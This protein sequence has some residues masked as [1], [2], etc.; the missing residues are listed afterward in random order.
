MTLL[1]YFKT[2]SPAGSPDWAQLC[3]SCLLAGGGSARTAVRHPDGSVRECSLPTTLGQQAQALIPL[4]R[5]WS[6]GGQPKDA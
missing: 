5:S 4:P 1:F 6:L 3:R 2:T